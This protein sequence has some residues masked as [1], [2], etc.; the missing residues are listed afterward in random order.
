MLILLHTVS[1]IGMYGLL[2]T[3][4]FTLTNK[5]SELGLKMD[6]AVGTLASL[7]MR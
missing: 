3:G 1:E 6:Y 2:Y 5:K 7:S 4:L